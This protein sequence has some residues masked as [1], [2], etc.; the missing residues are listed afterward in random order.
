MYKIDKLIQTIRFFKEEGMTSGAISSTPTNS[1][2]KSGQINIAGLP[3]DNPPVYKT[4]AKG[5]KGS[6]KWWLQYLRN[7]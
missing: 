1:T 5:G 6:R 3:P 4:Y 2:N 7:K